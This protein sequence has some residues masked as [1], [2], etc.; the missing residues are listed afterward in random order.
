ME[1]TLAIVRV[2]L[3]RLLDNRSACLTLLLL[4]IGGAWIGTSK[5]QA[6]T[7]RVC[8]VLYWQEDG[9]VRH[10]RENLPP[11]DELGVQVVSV[12]EFV[13]DQGL[14]SYPPG[15]QS[16]QLRPPK[17]SSDPWTVWCWHDGNLEDF[18]AA[19]QWFWKTSR[20]YWKDRLPIEVRTSSLTAQ[21]HPAFAAVRKLLPANQKGI[22]AMVLLSS[23]LFCAVFMHTTHLAEQIHDRVLPTVLTK[24]VS[25]WT[26]IRAVSLFHLLLTGVVTAP[27]I[28]CNWW[29]EGMLQ[30]VAATM[31]M[32]IGY[33][34]LSCAVAFSSR[35]VTNSTNLLFVYF[36]I[37]FLALGA[38]LW[39]TGLPTG[40]LCAEW[41]CVAL[42]G[43][44]ATSRC[45]ATLLVWSCGCILLGHLS[46]R[47]W[48]AT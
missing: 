28:I 24:P 5:T 39:T 36:V 23:T 17:E 22:A 25:I 35:S 4:A 21:E 41:S 16:I 42:L 43:G 13:D 2:Q 12:D 14:I 38:S 11:G 8:F 6:E 7:S 33:C 1:A 18:A 19:T 40:V 37:S 9:W 34:G 30:A 32:A 3:R 44:V 31:V 26:W 46:A 27:M 29:Q 45:W 48:L 47:R 15:S 20:N 10:L